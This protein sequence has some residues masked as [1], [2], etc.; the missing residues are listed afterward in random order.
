[1]EW[2]NVQTVCQK[3]PL[4]LFC[5]CGV[6]KRNNDLIYR[7]HLVI[8]NL[9]RVQRT[10]FLNL[11][12]LFR[13]QRGSTEEVLKR[14]HLQT[15][16]GYRNQMLLLSCSA[17]RVFWPTSSARVK[18][19]FGAV[20]AKKYHT[21]LYT[22]LVYLSDSP[23]PVAKWVALPARLE[24]SFPGTKYHR[25]RLVRAPAIVYRAAHT[26]HRHCTFVQWK[27]KQTMGKS[28]AMERGK[29]PV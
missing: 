18:R 24:W 19:A 13:H 16:R 27:R 8:K 21:L 4:V 20:D 12:H 17:L 25:A 11:T 22:D 26:K 5:I 29:K 6:L 15:Y 1:M 23:S 2:R 9:F 10:K 3:S 14:S 7:D 28:N